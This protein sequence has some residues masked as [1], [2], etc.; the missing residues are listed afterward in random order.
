MM[1][2]MIYFIFKELGNLLPERKIDIHMFGRHLHPQVKEKTWSF[3]SVVVSVHNELYH[4]NVCAPQAQ[5]P[6]LV[7]GKHAITKCKIDN[8]K[9]Y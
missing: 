8:K 2:L 5:T 7:I 9:K 1:Y 4:K 6:H 3:G